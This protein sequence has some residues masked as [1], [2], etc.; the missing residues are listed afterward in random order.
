LTHAV[1][2]AWPVLASLYVLSVA[3]RRVHADADDEGRRV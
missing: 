1:L 3:A 2:I